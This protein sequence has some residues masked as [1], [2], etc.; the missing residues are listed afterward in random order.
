MLRLAR[1]SLYALTVSVVLGLGRFHAGFIGFYDYT[2]SYR[3]SWSLA[4]ILF[5]CVAAYGYGLPDLP[6][7][8]YQ[9]LL[10]GAGAATTAALGISALQL[11][12][13]SQLL[14][15]F[16]VFWTA[17]LVVPL[18]SL[19]GFVAAKGRRG[20][21]RRDRVVLVAREEEWA[22]LERDLAKNPEHRARIVATVPPDVTPEGLVEAATATG[23]SVV[24]LSR[25]ALASDALVDGVALLHE[26]GVR[27]R[28]LTLFYDEWLGKLPLSE[29]E[30]VALMFDIGEIHRLRYGRVK[31]GIDLSIAFGLL[32]VLVLT[33]PLVLVGN[34]AANR[35]PVLYR[36]RR[37]GRG[38]A[39]FTIVKFRTMRP[40]TEPPLDWASDDDPRV[41]RFGRLLRR[42]HIDEL[43]QLWN[44]VRGDL[45]LVGPRPEQPHYVEE[46]N[47]KILFYRLRHLAR[48]GVTGWAQVKYDYGSTELDAMEKLQYD[49]WYLRHQSLGLDMRVIV[50]TLR[51]VA[52]SSGLSRGRTGSR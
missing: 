38:G 35:G 36:Q 39:E 41:T 18:W 46:L 2:N 13:G 51:A 7:N 32:P 1:W 28:T 40:E 43:P 49:F 42:T 8:A 23:A 44:V 15:R 48:P 16:V 50:R 37:V 26:R 21:I 31:R 24:V 11:V 34:A 29:L 47:E 19:C 45:S 20:E 27:M 6:R 3:F 14:P 33:L 10:A 5:L 22:P 52:V 12:L 9:F 17:M 4:Y 25:E 30:R